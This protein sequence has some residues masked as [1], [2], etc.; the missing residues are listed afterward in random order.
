MKRLVILL[1][2]GL[3]LF[4]QICPGGQTAQVRLTCRSLQFSRAQ[5]FDN[6]SRLWALDM[7]TINAGIN[8]EMAPNFF[9]DSLGGYS[10][11]TF[12]EL[13]GSG[14]IYDGYMVVNIPDSGDA[15]GNGFPDFFEVGQGVAP[16]TSS[17]YYS[18]PGVASGNLT[19]TWSRDAGSFFGNCSFLIKNPLYPG[20]LGFDANFGLREFTGSLD[21]TPDAGN[22]TGTA[23]LS[24][25][26][27]N[28]LLEGPLT[29]VKSATNR[30][31]QL[32]LQSAFLTNTVPSTLSLYTNTIFLRRGA[33]PTNYFGPVEFDDGDPNTAEEDY[34]SWWL[35]IDDL[36]DTDHD[37]IPDF[38][39]DLTNS[40]PRRPLLFLTRGP[41][42]LVLSVSGDVGRVHYLLEN[43]N[44]ATANW[45]TNLSTTLTND[46]Q[47]LLSL[48]LP[49]AVGKFFRARAE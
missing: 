42:N 27:F 49:V 10:N 1:S 33:Y 11:A 19:N 23:S 25:T 14:H 35:S 17:G 18:F 26:N 47:T 32:T 40:P 44:L 29:F 4:P 45:K 30:L 41:G 15:N 24:N 21:Y 22:V 34:Y 12:V 39:D 13:T 8:G 16:I 28:D 31:N 48:P 6:G 43:T 46:P 7:T 3:I 9:S 2:V 38:S 37:G 20:Y 36:N 5:T